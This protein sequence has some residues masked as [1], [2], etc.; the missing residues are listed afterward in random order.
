MPNYELLNRIKSI[1]KKYFTEGKADKLKT[2]GYDEIKIII[3]RYGG[4][5]KDY[6]EWIN[7]LIQQVQNE[8][9][10]AFKQGHGSTVQNTL[11]AE[12]NKII[13]REQTIF[14][15][16]AKKAQVIIASS[17]QEDAIKG[18]DWETIVRRNLQ[19]LN[20]EEWHIQTEIETTKAALNNLKR[21]KD[22]SEIERD[23]LF[24]RY[25]GPEPQRNFCKQHY[26]KIYKMEDVEN[27][28]NDFGQ[29]AFAYAGGYNCRHRWVPVF[30][31]I[32]ESNKLFI[33]ESWENKFNNSSKR[34]KE[35]LLKEKDIAIQLSRLGYKTELNYELRKIHGKDTDIIVEGKYSQIKQPE[36]S[37][38]RGI[39]N[40][41]NSKQAD[42]LIINIKSELNTTEYRQIINFIKRH[43]EKKVFILNDK[44]NT[45]EEIK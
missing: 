41:L 38:R 12:L 25:E 42:N 22:F 27:M 15:N 5:W 32:E 2:E 16:N 11:K 29:P 28:I 7:N 8:L 1:I 23:D 14:S 43:P 37:S 10:I 26:N 9:L 19:K 44:K 17:L 4:F 18:K 45:L 30:G 34:E 31:K 20:F 13:E 21:F 36:R 24:L 6:K 33:H 39:K 35:I 3:K 40:S